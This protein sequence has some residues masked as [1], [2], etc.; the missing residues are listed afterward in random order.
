LLNV[1]TSLL[2]VIFLASPVAEIERTLSNHGWGPLQQDDRLN[3]AARSLAERL[4][5]S[6]KDAEPADAGGHL[7]FILEAHEISDVHVYPFTIRHRSSKEFRS[8]LPVLLG[9]L[10]RRMVPTHIGVGTFG[11]GGRLTTTIL[12]VHRG[13]SLDR[14]LPLKADEDSWTPIGGALRPGYFKPRVMVAPPN[15]APV[16]DRPGWTGERRVDVNVYFDAGPGVY[17]LEVVAE[18][19]YGPVVLNN[20]RV[21]VGVE[22]PGLPMIYLSNNSVERPSAKS[23]EVLYGLINRTRQANG[24]PPLRNDKTLRHIAQEYAA[25]IARRG[26]LSHGSPDTGNL[27]TRLQTRGLPALRIAENLARAPSPEAALRAFMDSPGHKRNLLLPGLTDIGIGHVGDY[28]AV[29]LVQLL[30]GAS[31]QQLMPAPR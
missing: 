1:L 3:R 25:E 21:H 17:G 13:V 28:F 9:R 20:H 15:G 10:D 12:L 26:T 30:E 5:R 6:V 14:P 8:R 4:G 2:A 31:R 27:K 16:R 7:R 24:H 23:T 18:S 29:V 22:R 19:Q 11:I